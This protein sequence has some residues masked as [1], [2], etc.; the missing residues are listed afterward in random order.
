MSIPNSS[1]FLLIPAED[2]QTE[3]TR[4]LIRYGFPEDKAKKCAAIITANS[5]D[6]VYSHGVNRFAK[7]IENVRNRYVKPTQFA[8]C[9]SSI[10]TIEQWDGN[11]GAGPLNAHL[12]TE[13]V[14]QLAS[15][16]GIGCVALA[17]TNHWY[18]GGT[19]GWLSAKAGFVF[20]G[21]SNTIANMP[22]WGAVDPKL[23]NNPLVIAVPYQGEAIVLDMAMS[24]YSYG[25]L[26]SHQLKGEMLGVA[27]GYD[28]AG[29]LS[30]DPAAITE[31]Q[32]T[33][34]IGYWKGAGL[35]LLLDILGTVLSGG[36]S[37]SEISRQDSEHNLSQVFIAIDTKQL[38]NH[39]SIG[40]AIDQIIEDYHSAIPV[41]P[42]KKIRYPG[43][44]V[45]K[46]RAKNMAEGIP[47]HKNVW[48]NIRQ[49]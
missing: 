4:I 12:C 43:E 33:L 24:Q 49:L 2:M 48:E 30:T 39:R 23:G 16:S 21:W 45:L 34:P 38:A 7:L 1:E 6:G 3:F 20:I 17:N 26:E 44:Q 14:M 27:G 36:L 18:R 13:R 42:D 8:A 15:Q 31:S 10:G 25:A 29:N 9:K 22:P 47:V 40:A 28:L 5:L 11:G 46:I 41:D 19:Y 32:R 37:T 35:S